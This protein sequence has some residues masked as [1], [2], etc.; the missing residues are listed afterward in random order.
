MEEI[1]RRESTY[2]R[3]GVLGADLGWLELAEAKRLRPSR[4]AVEQAIPALD[5]CCR[6][7]RLEAENS[8]MSSY[9]ESNLT[10]TTRAGTMTPSQ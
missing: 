4:A 8:F 7:R 1:V 3:A 6:K 5:A 10:Q 2:T 9:C